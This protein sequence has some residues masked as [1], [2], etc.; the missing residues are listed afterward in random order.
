MTMNGNNECSETLLL[1]ASQGKIDYPSNPEYNIHNYGNATSVRL[2]FRNAYPAMH[3]M[4]LHG[5]ADFWV[6][7]EGLGEWD[8]VV[9]NPDNPIRRDS[10]Q[11][12]I[13]SPDSPSYLV[14]QF[15]ADNPGVWSLYCHLV[16]HVSAG[17]YMNVMVNTSDYIVNPML[18]RS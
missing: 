3:T 6:L 13:G 4:H 14:I 18:I 9:V 10:A 17:L 1:S 12:R 16:I 2:I 11:M 15:N 7:A 8:G 5:H